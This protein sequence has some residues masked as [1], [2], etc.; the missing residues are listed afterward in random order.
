MIQANGLIQFHGVTFKNFIWTW[1]YS[2]G[3]TEVIPVA[4][5]ARSLKGIITC[6]RNQEIVNNPLGFSI[7]RRVSGGLSQYV[8]NIGSIRL[9]QAPVRIT[10]NSHP[11]GASQA[12]AEIVK[13]FSSF[14]SLV[15]EFRQNCC[16]H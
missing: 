1:N 7:S 10:Q 15:R 9:P 11:E 5:R 8:W 13:L 14:N 12:Y 6:L 2:A 3:A 4:I 16:R